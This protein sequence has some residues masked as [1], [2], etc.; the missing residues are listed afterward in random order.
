[1]KPKKKKRI[2]LFMTRFAGIYILWIKTLQKMGFEVVFQREDAYSK[3]KYIFLRGWYFL[4]FTK[5]MDK[6]TLKRQLKESYAQQNIKE[7]FDYIL[8]VA[9]NNFSVNTINHLKTKT[10]KLI[11]Y[12]WEGFSRIAVPKEIIKIFDKFAVF[13]KKD[14]DLHHQS[15]DNL[16]LTNNFFFNIIPPKSEKEFDLLYIGDDHDERYEILEHLS[17]LSENLNNYFLFTTKRKG[18]YAKGVIIRKKGIPYEE[19]LRISARTKC[20]IDIKPKIHNGLSLRF[21]EALHFQQKIITDNKY[22]VNFDFYHPNN[23]LLI[24]DFKELSQETLLDFL[25]LPYTEI[26]KE[27]IAKYSFENWFKNI[28][29]K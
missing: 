16:I 24:D 26:P 19:N 15:F 29:E 7:N 6:K 8:I 27:I 17:S 20:Q 25:N 23:I 28:I 3:S 18:L 1:M 9:P 5:K 21:F 10:K 4:P 12:H 14:Y 2:L 13:D 11:G 22:V